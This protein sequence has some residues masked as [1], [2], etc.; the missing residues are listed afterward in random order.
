MAK[1]PD[2][3]LPLGP[4]YDAPSL[5]TAP[6]G[7][8]RAT[9]ALVVAYWRSGCRPLPDDEVTLA[10]LARLPVPTM[11]QHKTAVLHALSEITPDLDR[12]HKHIATEHAKRSDHASAMRAAYNANQALRKAIAA[13]SDMPTIPNRQDNPRLPTPETPQ[14]FIIAAGQNNNATRPPEPLVRAVR[15][16]RK[17]MTGGAT[18]TD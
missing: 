17:P 3:P 11:R 16:Q 5:T 1:R 18:F 12:I 8:Y 2:F 9:L 14:P 7:I 10:G 6:G 4:I 13:G 15:S